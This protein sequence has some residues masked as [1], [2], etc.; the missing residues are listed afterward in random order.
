MCEN[1]CFCTWIHGLGWCKLQWKTSI[2]FITQNVTVHSDYKHWTQ[3]EEH[4]SHVVSTL[5]PHCIQLKIPS[6]YVGWRNHMHYTQRINAKVSR[7]CT[8]G[9]RQLGYP[10]TKITQAYSRSIVWMKKSPQIGM[11]SI[12]TVSCIRPLKAG[13]CTAELFIRLMDNICYNKYVF[14]YYI[15]NLKGTSKLSK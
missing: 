3:S 2:R 1:R 6:T 12:S 5:V 14:A 15:A 11:A 7:C 13:L 9:F 4:V 8:D 10:Q